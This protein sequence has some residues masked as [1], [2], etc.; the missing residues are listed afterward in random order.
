MKRKL[1]FTEG[2]ILFPLLKFVIPIL[3]ALFLQ[4]MYGAAD[5]LIV[6]QFGNAAEVSAVATGSH[7]MQ[8]ITSIIIG[9]AMGTTIL[10]AQKIGEKNYKD[11]GNTIGAGIYIFTFM[12]IIFTILIMFM[13]EPISILM[14]APKEAFSDTVSYVRICSLGT[15]FI[16]TYNVIGSIFRGIGDSKTPLIVVTISSI[17]HIL[18]A[19]LLVGYFKLGVTGAAISTVLAEMIS[20]ILSLFIIVKRG[21][22][23]NFTKKN[24]KF[25]K[26]LC[27]RTITLGAPIAL[28]DGLVSISFLAI[29]AIVNTLGVIPSA[30]IG[31]AEKLAG[32]IMLVPSAFMQSISAFVAQNIGAEKYD[33]AKK[34]L[35]YG[36]ISSF[37]IGIIMFYFSYF[38][39]DIL[40]G[41]FSKDRL[42][43]ESSWDYMKAYSIDC[44]LTAFLF[45]F[46]GYFN[47]YGK[48]N[49]V[50]LQGILGAFLI[51]IPVSYYMSKIEPVSLFRVGLATPLSS[52]IQIILCLVYFKLLL[53]KEKKKT[54][55]SLDRGSI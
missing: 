20:V 28:Q 12:S 16:V 19:L 50:M 14:K 5:L 43:I 55:L 23:F 9:F 34:G 36:I 51:R 32:F 7:I 54:S 8:T 25:D 26:I 15:I 41:L 33:R 24:L 30:G 39:G 52:F 22:P 38:Y 44:M 31:I 48:T 40:S 46:I 13:A 42:V 37:L 3:L 45:C 2:G 17:L 47:G 1:N 11:A 53:N 6:G 49:F 35:Y 27:F 10:L 18:G 29:T 21:L 4:I